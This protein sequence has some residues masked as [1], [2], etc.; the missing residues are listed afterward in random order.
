MHEN[1]KV[2]KLLELVSAYIPH[3]IVVSDSHGRLEGHPRL[4]DQRR[5]AHEAE[6]ERL[7]DDPSLAP[8]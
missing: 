5:V 1:I 4:E 8:A 7:V 3:L 2:I 6:R